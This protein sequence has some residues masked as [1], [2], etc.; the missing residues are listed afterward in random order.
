MELVFFL[1]Y[2]CSGNP[3]QIYYECFKPVWK[4]FPLSIYGG[5]LSEEAHVVCSRSEDKWTFH[6]DMHSFFSLSPGLSLT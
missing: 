2:V 6:F 5:V 1:L 3:T 4:R